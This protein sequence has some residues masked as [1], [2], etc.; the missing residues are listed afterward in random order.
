MYLYDLDE[1]GQISYNIYIV[2]DF[3]YR[4]RKTTFRQTLPVLHYLLCSDSMDVPTEMR[5]AA[6]T[7]RIKTRAGGKV[8]RLLKRVCLSFMQNCPN[9]ISIP[10]DIVRPVE[11]GVLKPN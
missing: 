3:R 9:V 4:F 10:P 1:S 8:C 11:A 2:I 7:N 6:K 5:K